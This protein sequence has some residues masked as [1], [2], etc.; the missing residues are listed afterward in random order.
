MKERSEQ[1]LK[2]LRAHLR[3]DVGVWKKSK[4]KVVGSVLA[5]RIIQSDNVAKEHKE[6]LRKKLIRRWGHFDEKQVNDRLRF[7]TLLHDVTFSD[8]DYIK[9]SVESFIDRMNSV[10][11]SCLVGNNVRILGSIETEI[12]KLNFFDKRKRDVIKDIIE[13]SSISKFAD[14]SIDSS[15]C[16]V[17]GH[18]IVDL[19][20]VGSSNHSLLEDCLKKEWSGNYQV[21]LEHFYSLDKQSLKKSFSNLAGYLTKGSNEGLKYKA[22]FGRETEESIERAAIKAGKTVFSDI[23]SLMDELSL[24]VEEIKVLV[25]VT[26]WMMGLSNKRDG[27]LY[28]W[29]D[30]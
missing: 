12:I 16:L 9:E 6:R 30:D 17:H 3:H 25:E 27:Y 15:Y 13:R 11:G 26:D 10:L 8:F 18:F 21:R 4:L 2:I 1:T 28:R 7:L 22:E 5:N 14:M 23:E 29:N 24:S 20:E 19:G